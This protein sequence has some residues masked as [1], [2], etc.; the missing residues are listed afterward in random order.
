MIPY[1]LPDSTLI[2][3]EYITAVGK[4]RTSS[5]RDN[6]QEYGIHLRDGFDCTVNEKELPREIFINDLRK[7]T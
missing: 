5:I 7:L 1:T 4:L 6:I 2:N 3:L